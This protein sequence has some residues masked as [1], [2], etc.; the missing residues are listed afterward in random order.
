MIWLL[1]TAHAATTSFYPGASEAVAVYDGD[2]REGAVDGVRVART[3][4]LVVRTDDPSALR[5][6]PEVAAVVPLRGHVVRIEVRRGVDEIELARRL[7]G[8]RGI[9][10][11]H[12]DF[13]RRAVPTSIPNDPYF[14][15]QWHL[16]NTGQWGS[17]TSPG[18]DIRA[19]EAWELSTGRG[20]IIADI[21][22]GVDLGHPDL[23]VIAGR[24][25]V[26]DDD[27]PSPGLEW[28]DGHGTA[29]S[30]L[31]AAIGNNALG[32]TGVAYD[33]DVYAIRLLGGAT[34]MSDFYNA[35]AEAVDAGAWV[36][37]NSW[38]YSDGCP[39]VPL[40]GIERDALEYAETVG[41]GGLGSVVVF[42]AGNGGCDIEDNELLAYPTVIAVSATGGTDDLE[43]YSSFGPH[44]DMAAPAGVLTTDRVG[45]VGYGVWEDDTAYWG[46]FTG[47]SASC[48]VVAGTAAL[49]LSANPRLTAADV[50]VALCDTAERMDLVDA[51]WDESGWSPYYGCGRVDAAAA[52]W[53]TADEGAPA[54]P[55]LVSPVHE[56]YD[57]RVVLE[58]RTDE[59]DRLT[60]EVTWSVDGE[61]TLVET[62]ATSIDLTESV[63]AGD[64]VEWTVTAVDRWGP[65]AVTTGSFT[66]LAIP[67]PPKPDED[68]GGCASA[69]GPGVL[70][71]IALLLTLSARR[72]P[73][74]SRRTR[75]GASG[76]STASSRRSP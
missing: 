46:P 45:D 54:A 69:R 15:E 8:T 29:T 37:S 73:A 72:T 67:D 31:A 35:F 3:G 24:D 62:E 32:V 63:V 6:M 30:G 28:D 64:V 56:T 74:G 20:A 65:G 4:A 47:T 49:M 44:V 58:W 40:Y 21:D 2:A 76:A 9:T 57:D 5:A 12:P 52:V 13:A 68:A 38:G 7:H 1:A 60:Y 19:P 39:N 16:E 36:L 59:P 34:S 75:S 22:T 48:P 43:W 10:W 51:E 55:V 17:S 61:P 23:R 18:V 26:D 42:S 41:R 25:Y 14:A 50:R 66:V 70:G 11:A 33:A 71:W 53:A 27:D